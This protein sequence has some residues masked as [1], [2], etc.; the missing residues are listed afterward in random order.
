MTTAK[1][2]PQSALQRP[3]TKAV[4]E[5]FPRQGDWS[6][7]D[8]WPLAEYNRIVELS[9]GKLIVLPM[10]TTEHQDIVFNIAVALR[11][12]VNANKL[13]KVSIAPLPVRLWPN[14][15]RE[16]D[17]LVML[18]ANLHRVQSQFW[19]PPDLAVEVVSPSTQRADRKEKLLEYAA[20]G[21]NEYWIVSAESQAVEVYR[22]EEERYILDETYSSATNDQV[23]SRVIAGFTVACA[24]ISAQDKA[25]R[26]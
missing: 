17:V 25:L 5:L 6:E 8:Y 16:P 13:G 11:T 26:A 14:K 23:E 22:L 2:T 20:A 3:L 9:D 24:D 10:P 12:F 19:G 4:A 1:T 21:V 15:I 18:N 7:S